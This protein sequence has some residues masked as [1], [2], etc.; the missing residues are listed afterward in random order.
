M[1]H[2]APPC[3]LQWRCSYSPRAPGMH[4]ASTPDP[5][6]C[7]L[8]GALAA[9]TIMQAVASK[10][11]PAPPPPAGNLVK[12]AKMGDLLKIEWLLGRGAVLEE[13][14]AVRSGSNVHVPQAECL[15]IGH[16]QQ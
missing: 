16:V 14:D 1:P 9:V 5:F 4:P 2:H 6:A 10:Q 11:D 15:H 7:T 8:T 3:I 12:A 13:K